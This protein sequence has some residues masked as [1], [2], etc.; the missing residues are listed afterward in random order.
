MSTP[1]TK[2]ADSETDSRFASMAVNDWEPENSG[3]SIPRKHSAYL[4][5]IGAPRTIVN[6]AVKHGISTGS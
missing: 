6:K 1:A 3:L 4:N 5:S 2:L